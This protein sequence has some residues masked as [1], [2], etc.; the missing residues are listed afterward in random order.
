M[1]AGFHFVDCLDVSALLGTLRTV[2]ETNF[3]NS[4]ASVSLEAAKSQASA[5]DS[6]KATNPS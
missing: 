2:S 6:K 5:D 1:S 3:E 4:S